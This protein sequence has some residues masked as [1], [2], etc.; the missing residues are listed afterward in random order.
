MDHRL[1][2]ILLVE[3]NPD[4]V[5]LTLRALRKDHLANRVYV[6][7]DGA[8]ALDYLFAT[9]PHEGRSLSYKPRVIILDLNLP[10]VN[11]FEVL[12]RLRADDRTKY[13]PVVIL[14]SSQQ[15]SDVETS[16]RL[17]ANSYISKPLAFDRFSSAVSQLGTYWVLVNEQPA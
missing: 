5:E 10:R 12:T 6:A 13:I 17:G 9:G 15:E 11:G 8:E 7:K 2:D 4:H 16:Y 1:V 14:T 3:D